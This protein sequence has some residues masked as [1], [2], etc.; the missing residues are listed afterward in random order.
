LHAA[1]DYVRK[2]WWG[3]GY[4]VHEQAYEV[5]GVQCANLEAAT[6]LDPTAPMILIGAHYD[7]VL[8][9]PGA[10]DNGTGVAALLELSRLFAGT[11][12]HSLRFAAF[13]NEE[14]P[15]FG[16]DFQGSELYAR[17]AHR[18]G[19]NIELMIALETLGY[20]STEPGSQ[21]Y[22]PLLRRFYPD[23]GDFVAMVSNLRSRLKLRRFVEAFRESTDFPVEHLASPSFIPGVDWSDHRAFWRHGYSAIMV[24]DTALY[25]YPY[26]HTALD[27]VEH[28]SCAKLADVTLGLAGAVDRMRQQTLGGA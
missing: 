6:S 3:Q 9:S 4:V 19:W 14:S 17:R 16:T 24:T 8:G 10:N 2:Q 26:Y 5:G 21:A 18:E 25:R 12:G 22:P 27:T 11:P 23:R 20:Y 15:F 1:A 28:V 13:V 7:S